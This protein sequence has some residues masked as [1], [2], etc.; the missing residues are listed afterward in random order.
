MDDLSHTLLGADILRH[1]L[2]PFKP[3]DIAQLHQFKAQFRC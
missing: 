3:A 2:E 1:G